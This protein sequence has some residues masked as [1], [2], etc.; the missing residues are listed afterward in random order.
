MATHAWTRCRDCA[1]GYMTG[2]VKSGIRRASRPLP[3]APGRKST[4]V[5]TSAR[6]RW[7]CDPKNGYRRSLQRAELAET[8]FGMPHSPRRGPR[9]QLARYLAASSFARDCEIDERSN[10]PGLITFG[11]SVYDVASVEGLIWRAYCSR[12]ESVR[13]IE[14]PNGL[15]TCSIAGIRPTG[16][17]SGEAECHMRDDHRTARPMNANMNAIDEQLSPLLPCNIGVNAS[18]ESGE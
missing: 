6:S 10:D 15:R 8:R 2:A 13:S 12:T 9:Y 7:K 16:S 3:G 4:Y 17:T 5:S 18:F 14:R 11:N 1:P